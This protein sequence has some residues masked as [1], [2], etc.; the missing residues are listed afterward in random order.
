MVYW[1]SFIRKTT[2]ANFIKN[3]LQKLYKIPV[4][5]LDGDK[6]RN[7]LN[8]TRNYTPRNR[9]ESVKFY[10]HLSKILLKSN[11]LLIVSA[12]HALKEQRKAV[13]SALGK[14]YCEIWISTPLNVCKKRD[15]KGLYLKA[16]KGEIKNLIG[17]DFKIR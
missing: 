5:V 14:K 3:Y 8:S 11:L 6:I 7:L 9:I 17:Y 2:I 4:V 10:I 13:S 1:L 15:V 16:K 12:N